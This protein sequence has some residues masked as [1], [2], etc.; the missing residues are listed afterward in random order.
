MV[1][2]AELTPVALINAINAG[3]FYASTGVRLTDLQFDQQ[4]GEMRVLIEEEQGVTYVTEFI[5]TPA[6]YDRSSMPV[7]DADGA[8]LPV[9][10]QYSTDVGRV[11]SK[12]EGPTATY[13]LKGNELYV[14]ARVTSSKAHPNPSIPEQ[15]EQAWTQPVGWER[16]LT[17]P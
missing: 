5:G 8:E 9:T 6:D 10:R 3:D 11:L 12:V 2:A 16:R 14:R 15:R 7:R 13:K 1:R 17:A 4:Q